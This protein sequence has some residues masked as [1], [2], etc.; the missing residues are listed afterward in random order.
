MSI[1]DLLSFLSANDLLSSEEAAR[2]SLLT[3]AEV[4]GHLSRKDRPWRK[5]VGRFLAAKLPSEP[6]EAAEWTY[7]LA[8]G[9]VTGS[10]KSESSILEAVD[11]DCLAFFL[12][13]TKGTPAD[14]ALAS[15][16]VLAATRMVRLPIPP[17]PS[18]LV[19]HVNHLLSDL[20][21]PAPTS[22]CVGILDTRRG[23][24]DYSCGGSP[25]PLLYRSSESEVE[26]CAEGLGTPVGIERDSRYSTGYI[27]L[28]RGDVLLFST[29]GLWKAGDSDDF[30]M[31]ASQWRRRLRGFAERPAAGIRTGLRREVRQHLKQKRTGSGA[32]VMVIKRGTLPLYQ[33]WQRR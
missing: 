11:T 23:V 3:G 10:G 8:G 6:V 13:E 12:W 18:G 4:Y 20:S 15:L 28:A 24:V 21:A 22:L 1:E 17:G 33:R 31:T 2:L 32:T 9:R 16:V 19:R 29:G 7:Q 14:A 26:E 5:E 27:I 30:V 25:G